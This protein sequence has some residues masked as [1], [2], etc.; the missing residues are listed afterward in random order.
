MKLSP[1][2]TT[3]FVYSTLAI[4]L[5]LGWQVYDLLKSQFTLLRHLRQKRPQDLRRLDPERAL[6]PAKQVNLRVLFR[7]IRRLEPGDAEVDALVAQINRR[8]LRLVA[9]AFLP[10]A[11]FLLLAGITWLGR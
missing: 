8:R 11:N 1:A 2:L 6:T 10:L 5:F 9:W 3:Y 4:A 7:L